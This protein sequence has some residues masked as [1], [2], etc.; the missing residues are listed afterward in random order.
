MAAKI[1]KSSKGYDRLVTVNELKIWCEEYGY[2]AIKILAEVFD[3]L[4]VT[5]S[6]IFKGVVTLP[7]GT[8]ITVIV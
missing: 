2:N 7:C 6:K 3:A 1:Y 8:T 4:D 5:S